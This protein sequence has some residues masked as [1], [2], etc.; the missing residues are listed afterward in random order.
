MTTL[1]DL[2][3]EAAHKIDTYRYP[4][5]DAWLTAILPILKEYGCNTS[6]VEFIE[7]ILDEDDKYII[8]SYRDEHSD[9]NSV[10]IDREL[11]FSDDP[12]EWAKRANKERKI[13]DLEYHINNKQVR[14][15]NLSSQI[16]DEM[17][18]LKRLNDKLKLL[19][20]S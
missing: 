10:T 5:V 4:D 12:L 7:G 8:I 20:D 14:I 18:Q 13:R 3:V 1:Y 11:F 6:Q 16:S 2:T 17:E 19:Q 15:A 9:F